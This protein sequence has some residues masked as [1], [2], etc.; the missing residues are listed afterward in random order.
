MGDTLTH[1]GVKG[2]KWGV[3][4][5]QNKDGS[6][7]DKGKKRYSR[8]ST[9]DVD[10]QIQRQYGT[11]KLRDVGVVV[12]TGIATLGM[13]SGNPAIA[14]GATYIGSTI[15]SATSIASIAKYYR[16]GHKYVHKYD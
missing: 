4:R 2:M 12:G 5:Y 1:Y 9:R 3:R 16:D 13:L 8:L 14:V 10:E 11:S 15:T 6:L 7:T